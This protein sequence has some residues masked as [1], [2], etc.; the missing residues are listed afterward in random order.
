MRFFT[1]KQVQNDN[2][3]APLGHPPLHRE[4]FLGGDLNTGK[5]FGENPRLKIAK[6]AES[7]ERA[8]G[9]QAKRRRAGG[10]R[11]TK[12]AKKFFQRVNEVSKV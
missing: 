6:T 3:P 4:G 12:I 5:G 11:E 8:R 9:R 1:C 7:A 2:P 10:E